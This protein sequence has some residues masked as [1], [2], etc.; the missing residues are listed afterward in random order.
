MF[1]LFDDLLDL[2]VDDVVIVKSA[3][4]GQLIVH[5]VLVALQELTHQWKIV[6][7]SAAHDLQ[8]LIAIDETLLLTPAVLRIETLARITSHRWT[9]ADPETCRV[10][11]LVARSLCARI[12]ASLRKVTRDLVAVQ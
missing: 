3:S 9:S 1:E 10:G 7:L 2:G 8:L 4:L 11:V 5:E 12:R 6:L